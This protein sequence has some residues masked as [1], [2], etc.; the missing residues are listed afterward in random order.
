MLGHCINFAPVV[1]LCC[2]NA[3]DSIACVIG[4]FWLENLVRGTYGLVTCV[5][6]LRDEC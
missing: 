2:Y 6:L 3:F 5:P 4:L 1:K